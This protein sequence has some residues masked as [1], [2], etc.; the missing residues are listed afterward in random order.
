MKKLELTLIKA[1]K[2]MTETD[3]YHD[4]KNEFVSVSN[5][6]NSQITKL[7]ERGLV[8]PE[9]IERL[10]KSTEV[11]K[12]Y[13]S[14]GLN[15]PS[16]DLVREQLLQTY[17]NDYKRSMIETI[18]HWWG[19]LYSDDKFKNQL[20]QILAQCYSNLAAPLSEQDTKLLSQKLGEIENSLWHE[21]K[22]EIKKQGE[23][24]RYRVGEE[25]FKTYIPRTLEQIEN[26][27]KRKKLTVVS[28]SEQSSNNQSYSPS[29]ENSRQSN[30]TKKK[31]DLFE[32]LGKSIDNVINNA[33]GSNS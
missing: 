32:K 19:R 16:L 2:R 12:E 7:L 15:E 28:Y 26:F 24:N 17:F 25:F 31:F 4:L 22:S 6:I 20:H 33:F 18:N 11:Y 10:K 3:F 9:E 14:R 13:L 21:F 29:N 1:T 27:Y 5:E 8:L 23:I 30:H